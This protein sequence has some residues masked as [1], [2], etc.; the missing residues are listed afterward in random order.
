MNSALELESCD[1]IFRQGK[2]NFALTLDPL[3]HFMVKHAPSVIGIH[4]GVF[5]HSELTK[6]GVSNETDNLNP[7]RTIDQPGKNITERF[8]QDVSIVV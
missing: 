4:P 3:V 8:Q 2:F 1:R 7:N 6:Y 5:P